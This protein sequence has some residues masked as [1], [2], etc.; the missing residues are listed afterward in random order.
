LLNN[1]CGKMLNE[2][3][4]KYGRKSP[5]NAF[6]LSNFYTTFAPG[7]KNGLTPK[8]LSRVPVITLALKEFNYK[9]GI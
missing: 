4:K 1:V 5:A 3:L 2:I 9:N 6:L 7:C 8:P